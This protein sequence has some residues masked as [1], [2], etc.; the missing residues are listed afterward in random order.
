MGSPTST[1]LDTLR[2]SWSR[3]RSTLSTPCGRRMLSS[4]RSTECKT[5]SFSIVM[6]KSKCRFLSWTS[7]SCVNCNDVVYVDYHLSN[8][9]YVRLFMSYLLDQETSVLF[10]SIRG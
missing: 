6:L 1:V 8:E 2:S 10:L 9:Y 5:A 3:S 7:F 4:R